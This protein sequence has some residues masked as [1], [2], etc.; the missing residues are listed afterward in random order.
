MGQ[1]CSTKILAYFTRGPRTLAYYVTA[2]F[3]CNDHVYVNVYVYVCV[4]VVFPRRESVTK[5]IQEA[6]L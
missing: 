5:N 6:S 3:Y 2:G 4:Y 1:A